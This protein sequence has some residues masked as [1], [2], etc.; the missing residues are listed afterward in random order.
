MR[1]YCIATFVFSILLA[2]TARHVLVWNEYREGFSFTDPVLTLFSPLD[3]TWFTFI[4]LYGAVILTFHYLSDKPV[5]LMMGF[6]AYFFLLAS[7]LIGMSLLPLKAPDTL[8]PLFDPFIAQLSQDIVLKHD[9]FFSGHFSVVVLLS[10]V[11]HDRTKKFIVLFLA[12]IM[13]V[14]I[15]MQHVHYT[16]DMFVAP[17]FSFATWKMIKAFNTKVG[18]KPEE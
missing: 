16:I 1:W 7:R 11:V 13:A 8:I 10:F 14:F 12:G 3:M 17:F 5:R 9:L 2:W 15:L 6:Q 18:F 4:S